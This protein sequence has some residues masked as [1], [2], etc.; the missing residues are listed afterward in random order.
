MQGVSL[1]K[2]VVL[3]DYSATGMKMDLKKV[4]IGGRG[5]F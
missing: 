1:I 2:F 4:K 5:I 3:E